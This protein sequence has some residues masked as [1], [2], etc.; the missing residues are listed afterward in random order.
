QAFTRTVLCVAGHGNISTS[1]TATSFSGQSRPATPNASDNCTISDRTTWFI[2]RSNAIN[3]QDGKSVALSLDRWPVPESTEKSRT[4]GLSLAAVGS[5]KPAEE[6]VHQAEYDGSP[7]CSQE[8]VHM[9]RRRKH[10]G[11]EHQHESVDHKPENSQRED[12]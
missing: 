1:N 6:H 8:A 3:F 7:E 4:K 2:L 9:K 11:R 12:G 10:G 5:G